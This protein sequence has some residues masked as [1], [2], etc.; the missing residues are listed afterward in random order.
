MKSDSIRKWRFCHMMCKTILTSILRAPVCHCCHLH[1][2]QPYHQHDSHPSSSMSFSELRIWFR[3]AALG[4]EDNR[5]A[6]PHGSE[7]WEGKV[8]ASQIYFNKIPFLLFH[9]FLFIISWSPLRYGEVWLARWRGERVAV[10]VFLK[11]KFIEKFALSSENNLR[12]SCKALTN[13]MC[14]LKSFFRLSFSRW[15]L[16]T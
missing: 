11:P 8:K 12:E 16:Q 13:L 4:A 9:C 10:K 15:N 14:F 7:R 6:D 2:H 3:F 1:H 5:Q